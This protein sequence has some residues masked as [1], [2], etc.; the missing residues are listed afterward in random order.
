M[1]EQ[2]KIRVRKKRLEIYA[3]I[4]LVTKAFEHYELT[5]MSGWTLT[6]RKE[7]AQGSI[8]CLDRRK[9]FSRQTQ[10]FYVTD[11]SVLAVRHK[12]LT[13]QW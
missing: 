8:V 11:T 10:V 5:L 9:C 4:G 1:K 7:P 2:Q 6:T 13:S 12:C 3:E